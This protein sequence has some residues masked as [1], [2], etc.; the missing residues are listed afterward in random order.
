MLTLSHDWWEEEKFSADLKLTHGNAV[1]F[2]PSDAAF[3]LLAH[4]AQG[5]IAND[6]NNLPLSANS[7]A[8][9]MDINEIINGGGSATINVRVDRGDIKIAEANP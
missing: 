9:G 1:I 7:S 8:H 2:L 4:A 3:H 5:N 6:F